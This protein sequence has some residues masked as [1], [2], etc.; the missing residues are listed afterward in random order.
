MPEYAFTPFMNVFV[1]QNESIAH[2][3]SKAHE[4]QPRNV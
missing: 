1:Q 3:S 4:N 2:F